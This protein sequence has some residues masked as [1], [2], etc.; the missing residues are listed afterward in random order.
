M[1]Y[2]TSFTRLAAAINPH[3]PTPELT[4]LLPRNETPSETHI[5]VLALAIGIPISVLFL[6]GLHVAYYF[7]SRYFETRQQR[8]SQEGLE[9]EIASAE[10]RINPVFATAIEGGKERAGLDSELRTM[11]EG[12]AK[13]IYPP[14]EPR[15]LVPGKI[16]KNRT[17]FFVPKKSEPQPKPYWLSESSS[18][19]EM[20][21]RLNALERKVEEIE[22]EEVVPVVARSEVH[23]AHAPQDTPSTRKDSLDLADS[24]EPEPS[25]QSQVRATVDSG[26]NSYRPASHTSYRPDVVSETPLGRNPRRAF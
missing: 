5:N 10:K 2:S 24:S 25:H 21:G 9:K 19:K 1:K 18:E 13:T 23:T 6:L 8:L 16:P 14:R 11:E 3:F 7:L 4:P 17:S 22:M 12:R 15:T 26:V 20:D